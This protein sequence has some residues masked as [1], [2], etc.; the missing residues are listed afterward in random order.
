[1]ISPTETLSLYQ[2]HFT[3]VFDALKGDKRL[4][5]DFIFLRTPLFTKKL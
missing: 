2:L 1:M 5:L 4:I 3:L